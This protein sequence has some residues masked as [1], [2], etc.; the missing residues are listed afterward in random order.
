MKISGTITAW[1]PRG[2]GYITARQGKRT[3]RFFL[4]ISRVV[5]LDERLEEPTLG[6]RVTFE[7]TNN[8]KR[9]QQDIPSAIDAEVAAPPTLDPVEALVQLLSKSGGV[10]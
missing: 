9:H 4:H 1:F 6:C 10:E 7:P 3:S 5:S 2:Y 8:F